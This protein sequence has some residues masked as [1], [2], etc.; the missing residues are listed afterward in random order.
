MAAEM[1][2]DNGLT[3]EFMDPEGEQEIEDNRQETCE[4][5]EEFEHLDPDYV[6][7]PAEGTFEKAFRE[8]EVRPLQEL[9]KHVRK[10]DF[11]QR[12]VL[13]VGVKHAR[14][15]VK[16]RN[17]L[18]PLPLTPLVMVDGAA[19]AGKS[20][21]IDILKEI[22]Q[23]IMQQTGDNPECPHIL[24]CAPTGT[25]AV[26]IKGQTLHSAFG[27]A[28][29]DE[30]Y[31]LADKTRDTKRATFKNLK[32]VIVDEI[33]MVKADQLY[34]L[35]LRLRE[36]TMRPNQLFGGVCLFFFGDILQL[37]PVMGKYIWSQPHSDE[38]LHAFLVQSYWELFSVISLVENH[39]QHGDSEYADILN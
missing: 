3:G 16:A 21:T 9:R 14:R 13:E 10:L 5:Q 28:F 22:V 17:G 25:A 26:N 35:D 32:F 24:V 37:K 18:N 1:M 4:Q 30:H 19:G 27:F 23:L 20:C 33:S 39:R 29:G 15:L 8:I 36:I 11:F 31:S 6:E 7:T 12:K 38:Y 34:Q 2:I